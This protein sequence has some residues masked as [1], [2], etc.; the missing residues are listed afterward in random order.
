[1][2]DLSLD[3]VSFREKTPSPKK[4][5]GNGIPTGECTTEQKEK[6][7]FDISLTPAASLKIKKEPPTDIDSSK[8]RHGASRAAETVKIFWCPQNIAPYCSNAANLSLPDD[9]D[10]RI[11]SL[12]IKVGE[13]GSFFILSEA[14]GVRDISN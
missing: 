2:D 4:K 8:F 7:Q 11:P 12:I 10:K 13:G 6:H 3:P 9:R 14:A 5:E 1:M